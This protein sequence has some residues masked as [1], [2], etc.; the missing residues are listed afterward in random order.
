MSLSTNLK[1]AIEQLETDLLAVPMRIAYY[2]D[3]P[4]A[5]LRYEPTD[6]WTLRAE[7][8]RLAPRL[9]NAGRVMHQVSLAELLWEAID[10]A[11]GMDA[12][13]EVE[14]SRGFA[15]AQAQVT[16]YLTRPE[17]VPLPELVLGR[18]AGL[19]ARQDVAFLTRAAALAPAIYHMSSLLDALA[20]RTA[21][22]VV[23][24]YPGR[25][26]GATGLHFMN[27]AK[28]E[29]TGNYRVKIYG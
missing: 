25:L 22:P 14:R 24:C 20:G 15:V 6:E 27:L 23:L 10:Q 11:E 7:L 18:L 8:A 5:I 29:A 17:W 19:D 26:E 9:A 2:N 28:R 13:V 3:L 16:T 21:V 1:S 12:L 4:F